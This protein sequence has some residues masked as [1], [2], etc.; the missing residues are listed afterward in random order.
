M[1]TAIIPEV[2]EHDS[3]E[4][5]LDTDLTPTELARVELLETKLRMSD[6]TVL[7]QKIIQGE[8]LFRIQQERLYRSRKPGERF[9]W[10]QYLQK[11]TPALTK[12]RKGYKLQAAQ[13]RQLLHLFHSGQLSPRAAHGENLPMPT[14]TDQ[15]LPLLGKSPVRHS[16]QGGGFDLKGSWDAVIAIWKGANSK[17]LNPDRQAVSAARAIY[18]A[19]QLRAGE[20][21][22]RMMS[23]S[24][25]ESLNKAQAARAASKADEYIDSLWSERERIPVT[26][27]FSPTPSPQTSAP[28]AP[29]IPAW[30]IQ[31]DDSS[32]DPGVE[33]KRIAQALND[34]HEAVVSLRGMLYS[35]INKYGRDYMGFLRQVDAGV[36]SLSNIDEQ[37]QQLGEDVDFISA[38]LVADVGEGELAQ[39]TIDVTAFPT[40]S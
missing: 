16:S 11:F 13:L 34:A 29:S 19:K 31:A 15:L 21:P 33:C 35:Q 1:S 40:R 4:L 12:N 7:E 8:K 2:V 37:V 14:G 20:D 36:Y 9:T 30:E 22:G 25:Q 10:E 38:L 39:S 32:V 27:D 3:A 26:P 6:A 23:V 5:L 18:E 17:Q 28:A 24:Q